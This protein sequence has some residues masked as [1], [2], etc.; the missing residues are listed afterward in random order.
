M[1]SQILNY[2][3]HSFLDA[4][5]V[6]KFIGHEGVNIH[7]LEKENGVAVDIWRTKDDEAM[8]RVTGPIWNLKATLNDICQLVARIRNE[9]RRYEF[10]IPA[11]NVGFLIGK[12]G[13]KINEIKMNANVEVHFDREMSGEGGKENTL[14]TITG[15]YQQTLTGLRLI[16]DR[17]NSKNKKSV[18]E[19]PKTRQFYDSLMES[20]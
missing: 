13:A 15:N 20:F 2:P 3:L 17:L 12:H 14:V 6:G 7:K 19:N 16:C 4:S 18:Y 10:E 9:N 8:V 11:K 5:L 1:S